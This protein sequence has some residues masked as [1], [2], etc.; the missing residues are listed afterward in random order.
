MPADESSEQLARPDRSRGEER[1]VAELV[2]VT[3]SRLV[4]EAGLR[5]LR[6]GNGDLTMVVA[7]RWRE[8]TGAVLLDA[9]MN[10]AA[11]AGV[12]NV[13]ADV[14]VDNAPMLALLHDRGDVVVGHD[15]PDRIRLRAYAVLHPGVPVLRTS[16][17]DR[18]RPTGLRERLRAFID[19]DPR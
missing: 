12:P 2:A 4:G 7:A 13:E 19:D 5:Q 9:V 18:D 11:A 15:Q 16:C 6:S 3:G 17:S 14:H 8:L 1:M 10:A